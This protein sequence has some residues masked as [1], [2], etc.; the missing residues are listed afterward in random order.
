VMTA[1]IFN[2]GKTL[3]A[4]AISPLSYPSHLQYTLFR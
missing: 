2:F 1:E 3:R 4:I